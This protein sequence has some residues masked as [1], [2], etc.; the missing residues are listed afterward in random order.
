MFWLLIYA[1]VIDNLS[2]RAI[3]VLMCLFEVVLVCTGGFVYDTCY[4]DV[5]RQCMMCERWMTESK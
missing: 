1:F 2:V 3:E 5:V 4:M